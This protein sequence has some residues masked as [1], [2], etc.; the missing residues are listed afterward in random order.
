MKIRGAVI[1][2]EFQRRNEVGN[3]NSSSLA[4]VEE[5]VTPVARVYA[6]N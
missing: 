6:V 3:G 5:R 4:R 2:R 1:G